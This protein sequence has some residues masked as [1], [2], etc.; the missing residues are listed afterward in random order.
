MSQQ[1]SGSP[2]GI[3]PF[4]RL[5][6]RTAELIVLVLFR[7]RV[8]VRGLDHV[9]RTGGAVLAYNHHGYFDFVMVGWSIIRT[10]RRPVRFLAKAELWGNP[11]TRV[12]VSGVHA[13]PVQRGSSHGRSGALDAAIDSLRGGDLVAVAPEQTISQSFDLLPLRHGTVRMAQAAGVPVIPVAGWGTHRFS[14]KGHRA[15]WA[16]RIAVTVRYG[17]PIHIGPTE[18][19]QAATDRVAARLAAMVDEVQRTYPDGTP[20]GAW[21]VPARLGGG[22]PSH[23]EVLAQHR[24][25]E[26]GWLR[27]DPPPA[28]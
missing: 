1:T 2:A 28:A 26:D 7:W 27:E 20:P 13:V 24:R 25:R 3:T 17:E 19:V 16:P 6:Q 12:I 4:W 5:I 15:R 10:M 18:D 11:L 23:A 21:W 14:T 8:D 22:A 9:P